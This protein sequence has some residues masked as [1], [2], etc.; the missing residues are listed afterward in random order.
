MRV[1]EDDKWYISDAANTALPALIK[2]LPPAG[3]D[4][5]DRVK[6][7]HKLGILAHLI[8]VEMLI[9]RENT[10]IAIDQAIEE[11]KNAKA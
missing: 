5:E 9:S 1:A 11:G 2:A 3:D 10:F 6:Y 8:G 4:E 7:A